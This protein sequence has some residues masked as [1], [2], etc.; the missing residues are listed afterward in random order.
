VNNETL[1]KSTAYIIVG[2]SWR[3]RAGGLFGGDVTGEGRISTGGDA[4]A[5]GGGSDCHAGDFTNR[6]NISP[7]ISFSSMVAHVSNT[8]A[9]GCASTA[10]SRKMLAFNE[11]GRLTSSSLSSEKYCIN[12]RIR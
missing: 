1:S 8:A 10:V 12:R 2:D 4:L 9:V 7:A 6:G 5:A 11:A 3:M